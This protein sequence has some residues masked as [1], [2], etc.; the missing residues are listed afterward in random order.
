MS[1]FVALPED[2]LSDGKYP[3]N[4]NDAVYDIFSDQ[5][6]NVSYCDHQRRNPDKKI[7]G[8][9]LAAFFLLFFIYLTA[10]AVIPYHKQPEVSTEYAKT[11]RTDEFYGEGF[12]CDRAAI[13]EDNG[14]ALDVRIGMIEAAEETIILSTFD[15]RSDSTGKQ[16]LAALKAAAERGV[17]VRILADGFNSW[18]Q[19]KG[20][21]YFYALAAEE[22]VTIK[23]YNEAN[24]LL[25]WKGMSRMHDKY[26]IADE[27]MYLLGGR[28]TF[29]YFL[30]NQEGHKNY[31]R[32]V[33]VYNTGGADSSVYQLLEYFN[34][35]WNL[36]CCKSWNN[37]SLLAKIPAVKK[38]EEEL[39][40]LY[41]GMR[42]VNGE[43]FFM[44]DVISHYVE[45]TVP[46]NKVTLLSNPNGLYTK[47]PRVFYALSKLMENAGSRVLI[48]TPYII[49]NDMMYDTFRQITGKGI[50]VTIMTNSAVNNGNSFG[51]VD[52]VL[53]KKE[54]LDTGVKI[55]EYE[56]GIS[57]HGKSL[58]IDDDISVVGSFNMDMK[59][60]YQDTELMLVIHSRALKEQLQEELDTYQQDAKE[61]VLDENEMDKLFDENVGVKT[62]IQRFFIKILDPY[63]RF[64][65]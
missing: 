25:P 40:Q 41:A 51:A 1:C 6:Y 59:S 23:I 33:F 52:Y 3:D 12:S 62:K 49:C 37:W 15:I 36:D 35:V 64:L 26:L 2:Y 53:H 16:V 31:D 42:E 50:D 34:Q 39:T 22:N 58:L 14:E 47:E 28:N 4:Y 27:Q 55:L 7:K 8:L 9:W 5:I 20:N 61:A 21:P 63:L 43:A 18:L 54:I 19:I 65:L 13:I 10:G 60:V 32:D 46:V 17:N 45:K 38:A 24:P 29:N 56:G 44:E 48:H 11:V 30:G 57:Y